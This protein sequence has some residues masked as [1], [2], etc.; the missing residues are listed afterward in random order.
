MKEA[1]NKIDEEGEQHAY[2]NH[3]NYRKIKPGAPFFYPYIAWQAAQPIQFIMKEINDY[4]QQYYDNAGEDDPFA[5]FSV[6]GA[7][8]EIGILFLGQQLFV[9]N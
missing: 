6:H 8:I 4:T 9:V 3:R 2:N 1:F 7:K 5:R